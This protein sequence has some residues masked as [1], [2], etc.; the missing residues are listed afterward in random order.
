[1][2]ISVEKLREL[3]TG[4]GHIT[5]ADF[6]SAEADSEKKGM[7]LEEVLVTN[8]LIADENLGKVISDYAGYNFVDLKKLRI[9][10]D[11]I[12]MIP[13]IVARSQRVIVFERSEEGL[14]LA[15]ADPGNIE[16]IKLLEKTTGEKVTAYYATPLGIEEAL[17]YYKANI[18]SRVKEIIRDLAENPQNEE[19]V[20]R[21]VN[22]FLEYAHD[23][24]ASDIHIEPQR[25]EV[26]V[27]FRI[28]GV[29]HEI[30]AYPKGMHDK[31]VFRIKI[32]A[33]LRT[34]EHAAAQ[35]GRFDYTKNSATFDVR[36]SILPVTDGENVVLRLLSERSRR[37]TLEDLGLRQQDFE[38]VRR[39]S[40]KPYGM[41]LVVGPT[42]SGK[43]T[44]LYAILQTL[45]KP[46]VN[47][48][49]IEDPVEYDIE[50]VQQTQVNP[51]KSLTFATG[52]RSIVRQDPNIIMV[53]EIRDQEAADIAVNAAMTGHLL[54]STLHANDGA[55]TF[56]RLTEMG[57]EPFLV[58]SSVNV[59]VAQRLVRKICTLCRASYTLSGEELKVLEREVMLT[60]YIK[61]ISGK[62]ELSEVRAYKGAGCAVCSHTGYSGRTGIFEV[63]EITEAIRPL[64]IQKSS[65]DD[66]DKKAKEL[67]MTS[68]VHDGIAKVFEGVTTLEEIIRATKT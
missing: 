35:D 33:R 48:M 66:I 53:G 57:V 11:F 54:L 24:R 28:D 52:L 41:L 2:N 5:E 40:Q 29:L 64:I 62:K 31:I 25:E 22:L 58:A 32:M 38:K 51:K 63:M 18:E 34:D 43:T 8:G 50:Y 61:E 27:R 9:P 37:L 23:N 65:S 60:S 13:E 3:L 46:S 26:L 39:A 55:T 36:V 49:T 30:V 10:S 1:M 6:E 42:G 7:V 47:I 15:S 45:N 16:F 59:V 12:D 56:P 4:P 14:K 17:Q 20:V 67:G 21:L 44:T 68:M 19:N